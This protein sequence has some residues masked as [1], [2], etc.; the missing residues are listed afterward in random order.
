MNPCT[1][2]TLV[3]SDWSGL[4]ARAANILCN[5]ETPVLSLRTKQ[6][7]KE[8]ILGRKLVLHGSGGPYIRGLGKKTWIELCNWCGVSHGLRV[9]RSIDSWEAL[10]SVVQKIVK[11]YGPGGHISQTLWDEAN[12]AYK[13]AGE[14]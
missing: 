8:A 13:K 12:S 14:L 10:L 6:D 11:S 1:N 4:S 9:S 2:N 3:D 5:C 7:V